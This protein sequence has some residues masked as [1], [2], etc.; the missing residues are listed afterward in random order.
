MSTATISSPQL[1]RA[2]VVST[3]GWACLVPIGVEAQSS[4]S[5]TLPGNSVAVYNL[6]GDVEIATGDGDSVR[7]TVSSS[8]RDISRLQIESGVWDGRATLRVVYPDERIFYSGRLQNDRGRLRVS[9]DGRFL[10][11]DIGNRTVQF[12]DDPDALEASVNLRIEVPEGTSLRLHLALGSV[13]AEAEGLDLDAR[14]W[15]A[16]LDARDLRSLQAISASGAVS[17]ESIDGAAEV[18]TAS[19][20]VTLSEVDGITEAAS[21]SGHV[22][23]RE[24][25]GPVEVST[26][27]GDIVLY[28]GDREAE[29]ASASGTIE[30]VR[31][32][33]DVGASTA[34]GDIRVDDSSGDVRA[35]SASGDIR[36]RDGRGRIEARTTSGRI[37]VKGRNGA[38]DLFAARGSIDLSGASFE[39]I[40]A[41]SRAERIVDEEGRDRGRSLGCSDAD[42]VTVNVRPG[43]G[44]GQ[45]TVLTGA[46]VR[47]RLPASHPIDVGPAGSLIVSPTQVRLR[48]AEGSGERIL[49]EALDSEV[50]IESDGRAMLG[51]MDVDGVLR[52]SRV[53]SG[54]TLT[55][56]LNLDRSGRSPEIVI[57]IGMAAEVMLR[58]SNSELRLEIAGQEFIVP[59]IGARSSG[60]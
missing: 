12:T 17:A 46:G 44:Q 38:L 1:L 53:P 4:E 57:P 45:V 13:E 50:S 39:E 32:A 3:L 58:R 15:G 11:E 48:L 27:S 54:G 52:L 8:G 25:D 33:R 5:Y 14:L 21:A 34:S 42:D 41:T 18:R 19:G 23:I 29:L 6:I 60:A 56:N 9:E 36:I 16:G 2:A 37:D 47:I 35:V 10:D 40:C 31:S 20:D 28:G 59:G 43:P 7:V 26:A 22:R 30:I 49:V 51:P 55:V 24:T